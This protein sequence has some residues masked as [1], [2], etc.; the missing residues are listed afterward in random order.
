MIRYLGFNYPNLYYLFLQT[1]SPYSDL[2]FLKR[3]LATF[4]IHDHGYDQ[5]LLDMYKLDK[6]YG[7]NI[8]CDL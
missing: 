7:F 6:G 3:G 4:M 5:G 8:T 2:R 1:E